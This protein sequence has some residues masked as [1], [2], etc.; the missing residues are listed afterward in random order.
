MTSIKNIADSLVEEFYNQKGEAFISTLTGGGAHNFLLN[1]L[2]SNPLLIIN[3]ANDGSEREFKISIFLDNKELHY[4]SN[5]L[6]DIVSTCK[7]NLL[8]INHLIWGKNLTILIR[9]LTSLTAGVEL[10]IFIHDYFFVCPSL[11]LINSEGVYCEIPHETE[12]A[13]CIRK[14]PYSTYSFD[15]AKKQMELYQ[16][17]VA[18]NILNWRTLWATLLDQC[19]V[20]YVPSSSTAN[21]F[22]KAY[23]TY[24][25]KVCI[26]PHSLNYIQKITKITPSTPKSFLQLYILGHIDDHKGKQILKNLIRY[27]HEKQLNICYNILGYFEY[28]EYINSP[29]LKLHG[30]YD[31]KDITKILQH[32]DIDAFLFL[33]ICPETFSYVTHEMVATELPVIA[34]NMGAQGEVLSKYPKS[35][36]VNKA[37]AD[38]VFTVIQKHY[39]QHLAH[40][41]PI[42]DQGQMIHHDGLSHNISL[43]VELIQENNFEIHEQLIF[44]NNL[45]QHIKNLNM[46]TNAL[47]VHISNLNKHI[48]NLSNHIK[49]QNQYINE[50]IS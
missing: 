7:I 46:H 11:N 17:Q 3:P 21:I 9:D 32:L 5:N 18:G 16:D 49:Q 47:N 44:I 10:R 33:S 38:D 4:S 22:C 24:L 35:I 48:S 14:F 50:L 20:I 30:T 37:S 41:Y 34:I 42:I 8:Y 25:A 31:R 39:Q 40:I 29:F 2:R 15:F 23:P 43:M 28:P 26:E 1:R 45:N 27:T 13:T 12:C 6:L 36:L 19:S